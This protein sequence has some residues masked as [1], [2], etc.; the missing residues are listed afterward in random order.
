M[1]K[2]RLTFR[3]GCHPDTHTHTHTHTVDSLAKVRSQTKDQTTLTPSQ[4]THIT[5]SG[6]RQGLLGVGLSAQEKK[7]LIA[8]YGCESDE[9]VYPGH[10]SYYN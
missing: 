2:V 5:S 7:K 10:K 6:N 8:E 3:V 4:P 9:D 1:C